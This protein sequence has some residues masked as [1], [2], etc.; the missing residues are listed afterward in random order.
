MPLPTTSDVADFILS[1]NTKTQFGA[2]VCSV[3]L[4]GTV[5]KN[6]SREYTATILP[7]GVVNHYTSRLNHH[8][9]LT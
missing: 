3:N 8:L 6:T 9:V 2:A 7:A 5:E 4:F 1:G